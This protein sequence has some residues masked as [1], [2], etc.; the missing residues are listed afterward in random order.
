MAYVSPNFAKKKDLKE[1]VKQG[2]RVTVFSPGPFG[3]QQN[4]VEYIEGPHSPKP[5]SWYAK[6]AVEDGIVTK[7]LS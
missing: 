4:G 6:V 1:A 2:R 3:C 7:V 5:H